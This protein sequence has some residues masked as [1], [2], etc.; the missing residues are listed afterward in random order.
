M[1]LY[2]YQMSN[3][4]ER[5]F[6]PERYGRVRAKD[7][8]NPYVQM[9]PEVSTQF[10]PASNA[11]TKIQSFLQ[12]EYGKDNEYRM[13]M[14]TGYAQC[15]DMVLVNT[16]APTTSA[17]TVSYSDGYHLKMIKK[18][19]IT[20][21]GT[22]FWKMD[23]AAIREYYE[24]FPQEM[25]NYW[26]SKVGVGAGSGLTTTIPGA[27]QTGIILLPNPWVD[28]NLLKLQLLN[29]SALP[30]IHIQFAA[31][32]EFASTTSGTLTGSISDS[33]IGMNHL[34]LPQEAKDEICATNNIGIPS[35]FIDYDNQI[36]AS[37]TTV[38]EAKLMFSGNV[39]YIMFFVSLDTAW[40]TPLAISEYHLM[41]D[42]KQ[43]PQTTKPAFIEHLE[44]CEY[45]QKAITSNMYTFR[46]SALQPESWESTQPD[47]QSGYINFK[48]YQDP[49]LVITFPSALSGA[50]TLHVLSVGKAKYTYNRGTLERALDGP[51]SK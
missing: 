48:N 4:L 49:R 26:L 45:F 24:R 25:K 20:V 46:F 41:L 43:V 16:I 28:R 3:Y 33:Y 38:Y 39:D 9:R 8:I 1:L 32:S 31:L 35:E 30:V 13:V 14:N 42:N 2:Y 19:W 12:P 17:G 44:G 21:E 6:Q 11:W 15:G 10:I 34:I 40:S 18:I 29:Q 47:L 22:E 23:G 50:A 37:G 27:S 36:V 5:N 7:V 51:R